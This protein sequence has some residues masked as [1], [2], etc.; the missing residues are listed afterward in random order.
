M[1][2][3]E[4]RKTDRIDT[5]NL[6]YIL[7]NEEETA[8]HQGMGRTLNLSETGILLETHFPIESEHTVMFSIGLAEDLVEIKGKVAHRRQ[9]ENGNFITGIYFVEV[10]DAANQIIQKYVQ[11]YGKDFSAEEPTP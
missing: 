7:L 4:K 11:E 5:L 10:T 6:L 2:M 9:L 1:S 8:V 3:T